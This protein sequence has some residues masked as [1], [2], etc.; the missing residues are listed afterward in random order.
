MS[1]AA[2]RLAIAAPAMAV[3][4]VGAASLA[5]FWPGILS[6]D[7]LDQWSQ[8]LTLK[9]TAYHPPVHT[10]TYWLITRLW[11][12]P[13]AVAIAQIAVLA[14]LMFALARACVAAGAPVVVAL[15]TAAALAATPAVGL[16]SVTLWKDVPYALGMLGLSYVGWRIA[17]TRGEALA[18]PGTV[19]GLIVAL[20][21]V[22]LYRHNGLPV[23]AAT[24]LWIVALAAGRRRGVALAASAAATALIVAGLT[25]PPWL[26]HTGRVHPVLRQQSAIHQVAAVVAGGGD[27]RPADSAVV[28]SLQ[29]L[30]QWRADYDCRNV[31]PTLWRMPAALFDQQQ[32]AFRTAWLHAIV[33]HPMIVARH[34]RCVSGFIWDPRLAPHAFVSMGIPATNKVGLVT[35]PLSP[36][37]NGVYWRIYTTT[38]VPPI[39]RNLVWG[40]VLHLVLV[41]A[42]AGIGWWRLGRRAL[43]PFL[44]AI[45]HTLVLIPVIPS[46]EYRL[47][48]PVV[49]IG[50]VAPLLLAGLLGAR[51]TDQS[52]PGD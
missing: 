36:F 29:P 13:A 47:Q 15:L 50:L 43:L 5:G 20:S 30:D 33:D 41:L 52:A 25:L 14:G 19:I 24:A 32:E 39:V 4:V 42:C 51:Q 1:A 11:L 8:L 17:Q 49:L 27:L 28:A 31:V 38:Q 44:P 22:A 40:P 2:R 45:L 10:L 7:S 12:T 34:V 26:L 3:L 35:A 6:D 46:A 18:S 16:M 21:S 37:A 23:A 48:Y 9:I